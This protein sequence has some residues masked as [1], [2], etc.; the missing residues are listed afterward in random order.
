MK[1]L[2]EGCTTGSCAAAAALAS[3]IWQTCGKYPEY[4]SIDTP[5]GKNLKLEII[6]Y[7]EYKCGVIKNSGDDPD[8]TN[9]CIII[10]KAEICNYNGDIIFKA[11]KGVGIVTMDG[12]K[13]PKGEP[14]INP[15][16]RQ[17]IENEI[18]KIIPEKSVIVTIE[19]PNGEKIAEKTF[20]S[21]LGIIG[22]ISIL[23]TTGIV[24]PMSEESVRESLLEEMTMY[25]NQGFRT[26]AFVTGNQA[27]KYL[28]KHIKNGGCIVHCSNYIGFMLDNAEELGF[29]NI[30]IFG[31]TGKF[32]KL[33][34]DIMN[35]HSHIA[36]GKNE[37]IC[38]HS[39]LAGASY[40]IVKELYNCI[41]T[42]QSDEILK[43]YNMQYI[44][45]NICDKAE[46]KCTQRV[47]KKCRIA[48]IYT[49]R[50]GDILAESK[51]A[52]YVIKE[53]CRNEQ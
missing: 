25:Y 4:V 18:R 8:V 48:V 21:R 31:Q 24:R 11:G 17:M 52:E 41:T 43:K 5:V 45:K 44:W 37:I 13:I 15:V 33:A 29:E 49:N 46:E 3:V 38:T 51:N 50:A 1:K 40:E 36:D 35:T 16:P 20:N 34:G 23:G 2:R 39:A 9:G 27:E 26:I 19:V 28:R 32:V 12:L 22:G 7:D 10:V 42:E 47:H 53:W 30:L 6:K 14:A